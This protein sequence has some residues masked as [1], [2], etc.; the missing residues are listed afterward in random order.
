MHFDIDFSEEKQEEEPKDCT[1]EIDDEG[2]RIQPT[3][4][5][6][7]DKGESYNSSSDSGS[8]SYIVNFK[9]IF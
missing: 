1:P 2:Y 7:V 5:W 9:I 4:Q 6:N 8:K 3:G